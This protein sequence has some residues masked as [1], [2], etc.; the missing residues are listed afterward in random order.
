MYVNVIVWKILFDIPSLLELAGDTK[1]MATEVMNINNALT[2]LW[3]IQSLKNYFRLLGI[4]TFVY[5]WYVFPNV[6]GKLINYYT[7][8]F[9]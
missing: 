1:D 6:K 9:E 2:E 7:F 3:T 8:D 4:F 5:H